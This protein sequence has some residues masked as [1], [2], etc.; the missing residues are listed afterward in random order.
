LACDLDLLHSGMAYWRSIHVELDRSIDIKMPAPHR[1]KRG[2]VGR[3]SGGNLAPWQASSGLGTARK[4]DRSSQTRPRTARVAVPKIATL[5]PAWHSLCE[6]RA[7][8]HCSFPSRLSP[9][10]RARPGMQRDA[11]PEYE[12]AG[13]GLIITH[14]IVDIDGGGG[15][16]SAQGWPGDSAA[17]DRPRPAQPDVRAPCTGVRGQRFGGSAVRRGV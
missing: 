8:L 17:G 9:R 12:H 11:P 14:A 5:Q 16:A 6:S 3:W 10:R 2:C 15:G 4:A 1:F 7:R 13:S